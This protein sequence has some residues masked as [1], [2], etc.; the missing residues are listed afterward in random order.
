MDGAASVIAVVSL[1][2]QLVQ[3]VDTIKT[4]VRDVKGASKELE[5]L[6]EL[7]DRLS[8]L[9]QDVRDVMERQTSLQHFPLPSNTIFACLKTCE[10]SL[11]LLQDVV[12]KHDTNHANDVSAVRRLKNDIR[13]GFKVKDI[14]TFEVR[15][16][17]DV[18]DL[19][20]ALGVNLTSIA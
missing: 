3:S 2:L 9:L 16:Q 4:F 15:I 18:N 1:A 6:A 20:A 12:K 10:K 19:H 11:V 8:A 17:R 7:L 5:R 14:A 13:L